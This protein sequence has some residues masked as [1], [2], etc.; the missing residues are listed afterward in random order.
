VEDVWT[1][2]VEVRPPQDLRLARLDEHRS[3]GDTDLLTTLEEV[4]LE[5]QRGSASS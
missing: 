1:S 3:R 4:A 2:F 5:D